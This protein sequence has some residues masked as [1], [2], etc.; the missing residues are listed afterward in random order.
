MPK[1]RVADFPYPR[2]CRDC[3]FSVLAGFSAPADFPNLRDF[4]LPELRVRNTGS[5]AR[6]GSHTGT[7][8]CKVY[9][10]EAALQVVSIIFDAEKARSRRKFRRKNR[11]VLL[12]TSWPA[13]TSQAKC[14]A[15]IT[16]VKRR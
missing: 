16:I 14:N 7:V 5:A 9:E 1:N 10:K 4:V 12:K 2:I 8:F 11:E 3:G 6:R 13:P 15:S